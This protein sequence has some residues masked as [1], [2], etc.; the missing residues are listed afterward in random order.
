MGEQLFDDFKNQVY[1]TAKDRH[2]YISISDLCEIIS[3]LDL[4]SLK[5][6]DLVY[7]VK[8]FSSDGKGNIAADELIDAVRGELRHVQQHHRQQQ[9]IDMRQARESKLLRRSEN[10]LSDLSSES[11]QLIEEIVHAFQTK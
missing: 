10:L 9:E 7:M 4:V 5:L 8:G 1:E 6:G 3:R 11:L 2:G